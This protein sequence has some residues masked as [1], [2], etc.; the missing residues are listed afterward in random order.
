M[1]EI[2][3]FD[4]EVKEG[5]KTASDC[6]AVTLDGRV[7]HDEKTSKL[8]SFLSTYKYVAGHNIFMHDLKYLRNFN[9]KK[10]EFIDTLQLSP[11]FFPK[12]PYHSLG[13]EEKFGSEK[14]NPVNDSKKSVE[15]FEDELYAFERLDKE[16]KDIYYY[17]LKNHP[18]FSGFF[19]YVGYKRFFVDGVGLIK[20]V[21]KTYIC[22]HVDIK[23]M[24]N[25][26]PV[27]LAYALSVIKHLGDSITPAWV[28][29]NYPRV[30]NILH[31]LRSRPCFKEC[32]YCGEQ[33]NEI[34]ALNNYFKYPSFRKYE[35][36]D[37]QHNAVKAALR[38]ESIL[39]VFPTGGGKSVTFQIPALML[40]E[41]E[42]GLTVIISPLQSL[43][44]D[45]V[46]NLEA[47]GITKAVTI[48]GLLD[49]VERAKSI[50]RIMDGS[51][52]M[53]YI[54]PES[55]RSMTIETLLLKRNVVRFVIDEAHCFSS[56]GHDF[57][58]DYQHIGDFIKTI[59]EK[60]DNNKRIAVS[61]FTA[62]AKPQVIEDIKAYFMDKLSLELTPYVANASR[63][64][65]KYHVFKQ[66]N[67]QQ[68]FDNLRTL[69]RDND[70][71]TIIYV[72]RTRL[73]QELSERLNR[74]GYPST[75]FHGKL[76]KN[77]K[78]ENQNKFMKDEVR[79]VVATTAFGMG[80]DKSD[81]STV[82]HYDISDSLENYVQEAGR[83]GRTETID[84]DCYILFDEEDLD[85]HFQLLNQSKLSQ[86]E[87]SQIWQGIKE[88]TKF[89]STVTNSALE[90]ARAAG[91]EEGM[92]Q[93][94]TKVRTAISALEH[95]GYIKREQNHPRV[96][97]DAITVKSVI[98]ANKII[99]E[100]SHIFEDK[101]DLAKKI[102]QKL[103][104]TKYTSSDPD[105]ESRVDYIADTIGVP[106]DDVIACI[107]MLKEAKIL[108][109]FKD[110]YAFLNNQETEKKPIDHL[111][112]FRTIELFLMNN[113]TEEP[114]LYNLKA[115]LEVLREENKRI[116]INDLKQTINY[117]EM[118]NIIKRQVD[119]DFY[120]LAYQMPVSLVKESHDKRY[121]IAV[122][123]I[124]YLYQN[125]EDS[126]TEEI[127]VKF[128]FEDIDNHLSQSLIQEKKSYKTIED[129]L[130][131]LKKI[132][133]LRLEGAFLVLYSGMQIKRLIKDNQIRYKKSDYKFLE[134]HYEMK[135]QQIHIVGE[136][137]DRMIK[138]YKDALNFV[139]DYFT[140]NYDLFIK[141]YFKGRKEEIERTLTRSKFNQ[142]FGALSPNQ[143]KI[144]NDNESKN[145]VVAAGPGS[146]KTRVL[147]HKLASLLL[148]EDVKHEQL[149]MLTFSRSAV[150]EFKKRLIALIG[151]GAHFVQI[152][153]FH[154]YCF[155]LLEKVG[156]LEQSV[157]VI[158][159]A[160]EMI[161][162]NEV[163]LARITKSVL[164]IDE[165]Q[166]MSEDEY[167]LL[168]SI[169]HQNPEMRVIAVGDDDQNIYEFRGSNSKYLSMFI[170]DHNAVKYDLLENYRSN[171]NLVQFSNQFLRRLP[172]RL[173]TEDVISVKQENGVIKLFLYP[174]T[175]YLATPVKN[176]I[177]K[178]GLKGSIAIL[179][180][181]NEDALNIN[182]LLLND[183][184]QSRILQSNN[185]F[186][187]NQLEEF[188][189]FLDY[190]RNK[191]IEYIPREIFLE[192]IAYIKNV[193]SNSLNLA[194]VLY[195]LKDFDDVNERVYFQELRNFIYESE[196][197]DLFKHLEREITVSTIHQ[198][199]GREFD[200]VV[201]VLGNLGS[202]TEEQLRTLYVGLTRAK[203]N[204][205]I[206]DN[207]NLLKYHKVQSF[208]IYTDS[209]VYEMPDEITLGM[210]LKDV[211]LWFSKVMQKR[212]S[213]LYAG[214]KLTLTSEGVSHEDKAVAK[215]SKAMIAKIEQF[216]QKNYVL[217]QAIVKNIVY[218][219]DKEEEKTYRVI[220]P[221]LTFRK[222]RSNE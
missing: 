84:A 126:N 54:S 62:T 66:K 121:N 164:V 55:L 112:K 19:S 87:I 60:K 75:Y 79:I 194:P 146:G 130:F 132:N 105:A 219:F 140:M 28:L 35:N 173:K 210:G 193:F 141:K 128:S 10:H 97:A 98:E 63:T 186:K 15:L 155:D 188:Y 3:F 92:N 73:A 179:T 125:K 25:N 172:N 94:E 101:S 61:C 4:L 36:E 180:V 51:A 136:Y 95:A 12:K 142:L 70:K 184:I 86:K 204:L 215:F 30:E 153:T 57:R 196:Y 203:K 46:D 161:N 17:L 154:S 38:N 40:G 114:K 208:G 116:T 198:A 189:V 21:F 148:M 11:L 48:N 76:D 85:K 166:D 135:K 147:V 183:G 111:N 160:I 178:E 206:H 127:V 88:L 20:S 156:S 14:N 107:G 106:K 45:Q 39:A 143:L 150:V 139:N 100:N 170:K 182:T 162:A 117:L 52:S 26:Y 207:S 167:R 34:K 145:I 50:E 212:T 144:I 93:L 129:V 190:L 81:V 118:T 78:I 77:I 199:K 82:I 213:S 131:F 201:L 195:L 56:W 69:L 18:H 200:N 32:T 109:Q 83:A 217:E 123:I 90:I 71:P 222:E 67:E 29:K 108:Q 41:S 152:T 133:C 185:G 96:F 187:L 27:E 113:V 91:W 22:E 102:I 13:K 165:A 53:L 23:G 216:K 5:H 169:I 168:L 49:P 176:Q 211:N 47:K 43:M 158:K 65:L 214:A 104:R 177:I 122:S 24:A 149:L 159:D 37:L 7:F 80:V 115:F 221:E 124:E 1:K 192:A 42:S 181:N 44:K 16:M 2:V 175:T 137:A 218:W 68:K 89:R 157:D 191:N 151:K 119:K 163:D 6:G 58:V 103:I 59:E 74:E 9:E 138:D 31:E 99:D 64:N 33:L 134:T 205:Y 209:E 220:L 174:N 8:I 197:Q 171:Q 202:L 120:R 110:L 72:S